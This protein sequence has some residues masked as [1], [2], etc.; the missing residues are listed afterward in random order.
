MW[1]EDKPTFEGQHYRIDGPI[2]EPK[3]AKP[4]R[5]V[6]LWIGGGG[7]KVTLRLVAQYADACN[8]GGGNPETIKQKLDILQGHCEREGRDYAEITRSSSFNWVPIANGADPAESTAAI[9]KQYGDLD[10]ETFASKFGPAVPVDEIGAKLQAA[11]DAGMDYA[12]NYIPGLA[13]D[14][15]PMHLF[16]SEVIAKLS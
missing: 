11:I 6:P 14:H 4:G 15:A 7:E 12:I 16:E 2:N 3:S 1:T 9:R 10:Y 5:K 8:V 13:Y